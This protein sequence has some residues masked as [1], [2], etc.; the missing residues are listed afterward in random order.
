MIDAPLDVLRH[1]LTLDSSQRWRSPC[2]PRSGIGSQ[3]IRGW[4]QFAILAI[5]AVLTVPFGS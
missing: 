5:L 1:A 4:F 2:W 3:P